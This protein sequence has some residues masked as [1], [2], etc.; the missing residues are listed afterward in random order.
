MSHDGRIVIGLLE[1]RME[2]IVSSIISN[3]VILVRLGRKIPIGSWTRQELPAQTLVFLAVNVFDAK[4][5]E[6][7]V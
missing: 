4:E 2:L 5:M 3:D 1:V 7:S 6:E